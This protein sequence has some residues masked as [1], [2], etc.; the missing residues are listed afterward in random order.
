VA[1]AI[2]KQGG[3]EAINL[4]VAERYLEAFE[5]LAKSTNTLIVPSNMADM[6]TLVSSAMKIVGG[7]KAATSA[8]AG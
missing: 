8:K 5:E 4:K 1:G 7:D 6:A 3:V 2:T